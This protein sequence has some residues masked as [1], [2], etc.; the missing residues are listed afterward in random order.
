V[1]RADDYLVKPFAS[2]EL[3]A[4]V[5]SL[6]QRAPAEHEDHLRGD[7][8][9]RFCYREASFHSSAT[10]NWLPSQ[11]RSQ[12]RNNQQSATNQNA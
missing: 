6:L 4:R 2:S 9:K 10:L 3:L 7:I 11:R 1:P 5:R 12:G 8:L